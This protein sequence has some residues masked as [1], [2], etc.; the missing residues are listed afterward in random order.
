MIAVLLTVIILGI[1]T[2]WVVMHP[3]KTIKGIVKGLLVLVVGGI[4][5]LG[6]GTLLTMAF[7]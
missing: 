7:S 2:L 3:I 4:V 1:I 6:L 5:F